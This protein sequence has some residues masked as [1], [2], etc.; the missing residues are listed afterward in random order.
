MSEFGIKIKKISAGILYDVNLGVRDS[1]PYKDAMLTNSLF[2]SFIRKNR[3]E[4]LTTK[5]PAILYVW[6]LTL[7]AGLTK[8]N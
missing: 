1:F 6:T 3:K 5:A 8:R 7:A 2:L 4:A